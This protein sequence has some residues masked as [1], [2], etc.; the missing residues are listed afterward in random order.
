MKPRVSESSS[1]VDKEESIHDNVP[2]RM[3]APSN[4]HKKKGKRT[5]VRKR[6]TFKKVSSSAYEQSEH[7]MDTIMRDIDSYT[8]DDIESDDIH[9][10]QHV[11][12]NVVPF[13]KTSG[14][15]YE[16][17]SE[18][19]PITVNVSV[20]NECLNGILDGKDVTSY[21]SSDEEPQMKRTKVQRNKSVVADKKINNK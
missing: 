17:H 12:H 11:K 15:T 3:V 21:S 10:Y 5:G 14:E 13:G 2:L 9:T 16:P 18:P 8:N 7:D 19:S 1:R 4:F 6:K 20:F